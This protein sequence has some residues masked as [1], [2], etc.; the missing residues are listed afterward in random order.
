MMDNKQMGKQLRE[1]RRRRKLS[2]RALSR[3]TG[4]AVSFLSAVE[5]GK[6]NVSV[7]KLKTILDSLNVGLS[8]FFSDNSQPPKVV[9]RKE[10]LT[11][12]GIRGT[13]ISY[14]E[15]AAGRHGRALQLT[16]ER[17]KPGA[18]TG[19]EMLQYEAEEVGVVLKGKL[20]LTV[21]SKVHVLGPGDAYYFDNN[22]PHRFRN[23]GRGALMTVS[24]NTP[25]RF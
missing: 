25:S 21:D 12:I 5:Q 22:R 8:M 23:V 9:Y 20:E 17:Y 14:R 10:E 15:V 16:V 18:Q 1:L 24:V 4:V 7:A 2:L 11:E 6:N 3:S 13:G 19:P